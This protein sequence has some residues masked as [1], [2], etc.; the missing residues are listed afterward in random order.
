M[1]RSKDELLY[2]FHKVFCGSYVSN[3]WNLEAPWKPVVASVL[4]AFV[5][6]TFEEQR[7][8]N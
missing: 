2:R 8:L 1:S 4:E 6:N 3:L 7:P 5:E